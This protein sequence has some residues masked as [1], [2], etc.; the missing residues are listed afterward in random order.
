MESAGAVQL[1]GRNGRAI[2]IR[3]VQGGPFSPNGKIYLVSD[4]KAGGIL[5]FDL[6]S[7][8]QIA[9]TEIDYSPF[10]AFGFQNHELEGITLWDT[11]S[12]KFDYPCFRGQIHVLMVDTMGD[13]TLYFKH[14]EAH[15]ADR[16]RL[17]RVDRHAIPIFAI[18]KRHI[19]IV[20]VARKAAMAASFDNSALDRRIRKCH[21]RD[22][23][24]RSFAVAATT[25]VETT[26][27]LTETEQKLSQVVGRVARGEMRVVVEEQGHPMAVII[28]TEEYRRFRQL[29]DSLAQ[30][31]L[32][33]T[34][35]QIRR[36]FS[37]VTD[38]ELQQELERAQQ[39]ARVQLRAERDRQ[40]TS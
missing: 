20:C 21:S 29:E 5:G 36:A 13:D 24:A 38:V 7:R 30:D 19:C 2:R 35:T 18:L 8:H 26:M 6:Q 25:A 22:R 32:R 16:T 23:S 17:Q 39:E 31:E 15:P 27:G 34:M 9:H 1:L 33:E 12:L 10:D 40:S 37:D 14:F 3:R 28:S 11:E 4:T